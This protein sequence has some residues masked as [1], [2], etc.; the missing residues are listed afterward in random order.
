[1]PIDPDTFEIAIN[2]IARDRSSETGLRGQRKKAAWNDGYM[3]QLLYPF[4]ALA[5]DPMSVKLWI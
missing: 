2:L 5:L 1:M 3:Q 4:H